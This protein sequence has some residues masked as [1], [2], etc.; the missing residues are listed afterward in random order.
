MRMSFAPTGRNRP[1]KLQTKDKHCEKVRRDFLDH[2]NREGVAGAGTAS[3]TPHATST[4]VTTTQ[5]VELLDRIHGQP[6]DPLIMTHHG[7]YGEVLTS[8]EDVHGKTSIPTDPN[9]PLT[10]DSADMPDDDGRVEMRLP[11]DLDLAHGKPAGS[12]TVVFES[13]AE[14]I[15]M[16]AESVEGGTR[17][18]SVIGDS[19]APHTFSYEMSI[20]TDAEWKIYPDDSIVVSDSAGE[21]ISMVAPP[22]AKDANGTPA[23]TTF[24]FD[25]H[26]LTQQVYADSGQHSYPI[27]ADPFQG[28]RLFRNLNTDK[29]HEGQVVYSGTKTDWG[30]KIHNGQAGDPA[31]W[32]GGVAAGQFIMRNEGWREWTDKW[33]S[34][35]TSRKTFYQQYS[36]HVL[37]GF[38]NWA[39][40]WNLEASRRDNAWWAANVAFHR[41]NW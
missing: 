39:G 28:K 9:E 40:D 27:I 15:I 29:K 14:N 24:E 33:G 25:G 22:W 34:R 3:A 18:H 20:P 36:C 17:V 10:F 11:A 7:H 35:V 13:T 6:S 26:T 16:T 19:D 12:D 8:D 1:R 41:C 38:S 2:C 31:G 32:V 4:E 30:Q 5:A 21:V 23:P 37:G